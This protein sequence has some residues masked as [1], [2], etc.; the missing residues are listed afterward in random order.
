MAG[1]YSPSMLNAMRSCVI[2]SRALCM[3]QYA[4]LAPQPQA[5]SQDK[6]TTSINGAPGS[7]TVSKGHNSKAASAADLTEPS[8]QIQIPPSDLRRDIQA[9][10]LLDWK[11]AFWLATIGGAEALGLEETCGTLEVGKAFDALRVDT[12]NAAAFDVFPA[13]TAMDAFQKFVNLGDD[14][15]IKAVWVGGRLVHAKQSAL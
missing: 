7:D 14:R 10:N 12:R 6:S 15:N 3:Q 1:G 2:A 11:G 13:D 8:S 5:S 9:K 4:T